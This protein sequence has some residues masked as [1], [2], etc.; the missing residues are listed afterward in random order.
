MDRVGEYRQHIRDILAEYRQYRPAYGEIEIEQ[1]ID[2]EGDHYQLLSVGWQNRQRVHGS[3][4]HIDI[5]DGKIWIQHDGTEEGVAN[6]L[7]ARGCQKAISSSA[8]SRRLSASSRSLPSANAAIRVHPPRATSPAH[9][10]QP[11]PELWR[12]EGCVARDV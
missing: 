1:V 10:H 8:S 2:P 11:A 5:R 6:Q 12:G 3:I 7:V 9:T 4:V